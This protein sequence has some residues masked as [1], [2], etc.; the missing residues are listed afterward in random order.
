MFLR[1]KE[2]EFDTH[3]SKDKHKDKSRDKERRSDKEER[4]HSKE[5]RK[6]DKEEKKKD[7][8]K[9]KEKAEKA[10]SLH[11]KNEPLSEDDDMP[12]VINIYCKII[13][14]FLTLLLLFVVLGFTLI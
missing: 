2:N 5:E 14:V 9:S 6:H 12:L 10:N 3:I 7:K 13:E 8:E 1:L 4:K 11:V